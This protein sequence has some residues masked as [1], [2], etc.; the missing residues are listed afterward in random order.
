MAEL[1]IEWAPVRIRCLRCALETETVPNALACRAC[2]SERTQLLSGD[3]LLLTGI[4]LL[5]ADPGL[6]PSAPLRSAQES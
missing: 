4:D 6:D 3:E 1:I 2:G 5:E